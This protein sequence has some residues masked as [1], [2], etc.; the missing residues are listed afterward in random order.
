MSFLCI[1]ES[2]VIVLTKAILISKISYL[3]NL[4]SILLDAFSS[5]NVN[6]YLFCFSISSY[7]LFF[8]PVYQYIYSYTGMVFLCL[9]I[10]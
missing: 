1:V 6:F 8:T 2:C 10:S 4:T 3:N 9:T 7:T 5:F